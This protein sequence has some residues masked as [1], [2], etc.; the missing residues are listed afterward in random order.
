MPPCRVHEDGGKEKLYAASLSGGKDSTAMV[1]RL[2]EEGWPLDF[3]MFCDTGLEFPQMYEHVEK[4]EK[5]LPV[6]VVRLKAEKDFEYYF[7]HYTPERK[8]LDSPYADKPGMSWAGPKNRWCTSMLKTAV[9]NKYLSGL[10][11]RYEVVQYIGIAADEPRRV[12]EYRYPLVEWG[13]TERDC[14][15]YCYERGYDWGGLYRLFDRVSCWCCPLQGLEELRTLRREFPELWCQLL[16]WE[17]ET[18]RNFR[19]DFSVEELEIRFRF[20]E[21]R[22]REGKRIRGKEFFKELYGRLGRDGD[23]AEI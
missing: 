23:R 20:E 19:K 21:E 4:L 7:L 9:I 10:R 5:E 2:V 8:D 14:L 3:V 18:W 1:L 15:A 17:A 16:E 6:P 22:M 12:K 11:K 13:M